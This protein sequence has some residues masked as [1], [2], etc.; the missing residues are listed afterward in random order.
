MWKWMDGSGW[1]VWS[2]VKN[3]PKDGILKSE[4]GALDVELVCFQMMTLY[5]SV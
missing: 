4:D 1:L 3:P 2:A 5:F